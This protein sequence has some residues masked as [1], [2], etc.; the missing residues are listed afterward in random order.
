MFEEPLALHWFVEKGLLSVHLM[1]ATSARAAQ[2][3]DL[4]K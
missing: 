1:G 4:P 3:E 2:L